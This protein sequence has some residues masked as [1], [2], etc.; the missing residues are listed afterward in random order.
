MTYVK[1]TWANG[2][3]GGTPIDA[4]ALEHIE[5]G[6][7]TVDLAAAA[8]AALAATKADAATTTAALALKA[9]STDVATSLAAKLDTTTAS[10]TYALRAP[11]WVDARAYVLDE[12][13]IS[14][15]S[16]YRVSTAHTSSGSFDATKFTA[17]GGGGGGS[18]N[19]V[20]GTGANQVPVW[21]V[22]D[23]RY[24]PVTLADATA[25]TT[26][27]T[28]T[29]NITTTDVQAALEELDGL[30]SVSNPA[31]TAVAAS[32]YRATSQA[33][34]ANTFTSL[35]FGTQAYNVGGVAG[36]G[37]NTLVVP[38]GKAGLWRVTVFTRWDSATAAGRLLYLSVNG[39][40]VTTNRTLST[41]TNSTQITQQIVR[42]MVL[43][44]GDILSGEVFSAAATNIQ[45]G[46]DA[47]GM[48]ASF[49]GPV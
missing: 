32:I 10:G 41:T 43:S 47:T 26:A 12:L 13:V 28:P 11:A 6:I 7:E 29:G 8:A 9:N 30:I 34:A 22:V 36:S 39:V 4:D 46:A 33:I 21:D 42:E 17:V 27:V 3:A 35:A 45:G 20:D 16:L 31:P 18:S 5:D 24:E 25:A 1:Q 14:G 38:A 37:N 44:V 19:V 48:Q 23:G 15:G 2:R 40:S 49:V